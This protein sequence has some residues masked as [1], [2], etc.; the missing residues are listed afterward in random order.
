MV[1]QHSIRAVIFDLGGVIVRTDDISQ[2]TRLAERFGMT[3][4]DLDRLVFSSETAQ[5]AECGLA[6]PAEVWAVVAE[7]LHLP[8]EE[9]PAFEK[10]F[11][12]GDSVDFTLVERIRSL[13]PA[14]TTAALSNTWLVD[15]PR[16]LSEEKHI[17]D[18]FDVVISS[19]QCGMAKPAPE[20]F[21]HALELVGARPEET[22]FVDDNLRNVEAARALGIHAIRF[23]NTEQAWSELE[24]LLQR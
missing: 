1:E 18:T 17:L 6:T 2:R 24:N 4:A 21:H 15:L 11:F 23:L 13:R 3:Y 12:S 20:I 8:V 16:Y 19:A 10:A 14:Y 9:M 5:R 22:I 7:Q